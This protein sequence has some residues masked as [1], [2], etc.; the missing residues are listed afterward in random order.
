MSWQADLF[1]GTDSLVVCLITSVE[2]P[3]PLLRVA[4]PAGK[5]TGLQQPSWIQI[6]KI[7]AVGRKRIGGRIG[8]AGATVMIEV[9]R[10]LAVLLR[11]GQPGAR[12]HPNSALGRQSGPR[13]S[14]RAP[15]PCKSRSCWKSRPAWGALSGAPPAN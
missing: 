7:S 12:Q 4:L 15:R 1:P 11:I 8:T 5:Q 14:R 9:I 10:C 13:P 6:E 3:A 2:R